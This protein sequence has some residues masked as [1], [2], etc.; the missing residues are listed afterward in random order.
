MEDVRA[1]LAKN[2]RLARQRASVSQEELAARA[3]VDRTYVS[4]IER[5]IRNP[6]ITILARLANELET[7]ASELIAGKPTTDGQ[8]ARGR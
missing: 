6:T 3:G 5:G 1:N 7:T 8:S 4:G 2:L